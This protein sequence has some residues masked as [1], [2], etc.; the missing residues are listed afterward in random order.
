MFGPR[1]FRWY[2]TYN[3]TITQI[4]TTVLIIGTVLIMGKIHKTQKSTVVI[5]GAFKNSTLKFVHTLGIW[6]KKH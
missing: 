1:F 6:V 3:R 4:F 5:L 2:G